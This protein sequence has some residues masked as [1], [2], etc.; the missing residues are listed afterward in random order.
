M[1]APS[2]F[3]ATTVWRWCVPQWLNFDGQGRHARELRNRVKTQIRLIDVTYNAQ[4]VDETITLAREAYELSPGGEADRIDACLLLAQSLRQRANRN[5]DDS[6]LKEMIGL[7]REALALCPKIHPKR[8]RSCR[9][10]AISLVTR[11]EHTG[12]V[13]LLDE[14][15]NLGR[16]ALDLC[17]EGH[18]HR[19]T[20]CV[21]LAMSLWKYYERTG[22]VGLLDEAIN[23]ERK[24]LNLRPAGH[25]NR[26][27]SC[28]NLAVSLM[29]R[30]DHTGDVGLLDEAIDLQRE[31]L[32]LRSEGHPGRSVSCGNLA[33]SLKTRYERTGDVGFVDQAI[34]LER[35]A[36]DLC[37][38]GHPDR[39]IS[40]GNLASSLTTR[41]ERTG[42]VGFVDQ[43]IDLQ[44]EALD[45]CPAGHPDRASPC[46][47]LAMSLIV[48]YER[49]DD[50]GLL[51]E[52]VNLG[53]QAFAL[54]PAGHP[55]RAISCGNLASSLT[56]R[57]ERTG[58]VGFVDQ[59]IDLER[60]ALDLCPA[61]HPDRAS[62]CDNLAISLKTRYE[63]TDDVGLLDEAVNLGRQALT[64]RP[65]GH[66]YRY[67]S[68]EDLA[69]SLI[70]RYKRTGDVALLH[71]SLVLSQDA[72]TM[73]PVHAIWTDLHLI[74]WILLQNTNPSYDVSKAIFYLSQSLQHDP[75][76]TLAFVIS[77]SSLLKNLWKCEM[78]GKHMQLTTIYQRLVNFLPL[79][80]HPALGLKPQLQALKTCTRLGS[81]A[82]V[83]AVLANDCSVGLETLELAQGVIWSQSLHRRDPQFED[84]PE[85]LA[86]KL[87][88]LLL[89][90]A[91][92]S[93]AQPDY[94]ERKWL[95]PRDILHDRSSRAYAVIREIRT[96]PGLG[97]FML[98][99]TFET[100]RA[101]ASSHPVVVLVGARGHYYA[102]IMSDRFA[103]GCTLMSIDLRE[104]EFKSLSFTPGSMRARRSDV[105]PA[106]TQKEGDRAG[107]KK[108][109]RASSKPLD[110]QLKTLW[111]K[112]VKPV[113]AHL[114][115]GVNIRIS[116]D[117]T[118][119]L[120][121]NTCNSVS[122]LTVPGRV[123]TGV[124]Q[125]SSAT[126]PYT[127]Q[128]S[129]TA[130]TKS[131]ALTLW[132][133]R[134]PRPSLRFCVRNTLP[135]LFHGMTFPSHLWQRSE[136]RS[137]ISS[138]F[139]EWIRRSSMSL[140]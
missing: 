42:D 6:L 33:S 43:A 5:V 128:G 37:P 56:T 50:V 140:R 29:T 23:L 104:E 39:A 107:L 95:T 45:L 9:G 89:S 106:E 120:T 109:E 114:G 36:L 71:E 60:E 116:L 4:M 19:F 76:D 15:I 74:T 57:Y 55:Y 62:S 51:D 28:Q 13:G 54:R 10:L 69:S 102:L 137:E 98:G 20:S 86:S 101:T 21:N 134:T 79:L 123:C 1:T 25:L 52:A 118:S 77:L 125:A 138:S 129:T 93:I 49:T 112:V 122:P 11:H 121:K 94:K 117:D 40:C 2:S 119:A 127:L 103:D 83:N 96:L 32:D 113:L 75:D 63:H 64:L 31:A 136:L 100:L 110:V 126:F 72:L 70:T 8:A 30:Y 67:V 47:N 38:A 3:T 124:L 133:H 14:A 111:H 131:A 132:C 46:D 22:N 16:E 88:G 35:E 61:G 139:P 44:R 18:P 59:A 53:R 97:R 135:S 68:C 85:H 80:V 99:E 65:A 87:Q 27:V 7:G 24:A 66:P 91:M 41:Y 84:V 82:F 90:S 108:T 92:T 17:S 58:D 48:R 78:I 105:T 73:A 115:L 34:D 130:R 81:D 26:D 12:D